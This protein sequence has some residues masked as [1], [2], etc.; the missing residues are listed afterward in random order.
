V[1]RF[2]RSAARLVARSPVT[3]RLRRV[4]CALL[5]A[6]PLLVS[7]SAFGAP[8]RPAAEPYLG[9]PPTSDLASASGVE[10]VE[11]F[12]GVGFDNPVFMLAEPA[13]DR[14][15]IAEQAGRLLSFEA[16]ENVSETRLVLD[17][18]DV[19][20]GVGDSGL[21][22]MAFHPRY[23]EAEAVGEGMIFVAYEH[24]ADDTS[25]SFRVSRF[26]VDRTTGVADPESELVLIHQS[27]Q[28]PWHE[29]ASMLF[30]PSDGFLYVTVG[31]EGGNACQ[32]GNCQKI[33][34]DLFSGVLRID[35]D[36][37]GGEKSHAPPRQPLTGT[38]AG[39]F[40]PNDNPFAGVPDALEEFYAIG[41]RSPHRMTLDPLKDRIWIADVGQSAREEIDILAPAA[42][43]QW[44]V[45]EGSIPLTGGPPMPNPVIGTWTPPV[46]DYGRNEG[47]TIIGGYVYRGLAIPA[48]QGRYVYGDFL[49]GRIWALGYVESGHG[50][51]VTENER[52]LSTPY[53]GREQGLTS[54][55]IDA[56]GEIYVLT[57]GEQVRLR[58]LVP[59]SPD[60]GNVPL[61]LSATGLFTDLA[62]LTT[63]DSL[64]PYDVK[65]AL[66][67]DGAAKRRWVSVPTGAFV[68]YSPDRPWTFPAGT[69]FVK[70]FE[71]QLD[72]SG[73]SSLHRLETRVLVVQEDQRIYGV[74]YKWRSDQ[75]D[76]DLLTTAELEELEIIDEK[77][78]TSSQRYLYP[79]PLDCLTCHAER[80]GSVLGLRARQFEGM[81]T[82][83]GAGDALEW[84]AAAGYFDSENLE[85]DSVPAFA[86]LDDE[87][88]PVALRARSYLDVNCSHC[89]GGQD[90]DRA[91][92]DARITV[93][94]NHQ[95]IVMGPLLSGSDSE[96]DRIVVPGDVSHSVMHRRTA[97][98]DVDLRMPPLARSVEDE[99]F[100]DVLED[101]IEGMT[102]TTLPPVVCG[103]SAAPWD[104]VSSAD[105]LAGLRA[106]VAI[107]YCAACLCDVNSDGTI[108]ASDALRVLRYAVGN[109]Q[110][111]I[112]PTC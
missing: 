81:P 29:G 23:A 49:N 91:Q 58:R 111:L 22:S 77:G 76:A 9:M 19:T 86:P 80:A 7:G 110:S 53:Y 47:G 109:P 100:V 63:I 94:L 65:V 46:H 48:L 32:F 99:S 87:L 79:G 13:G 92:W 60:P 70:H 106:A 4:G 41:L 50:I 107:D 68:G 61:T 105:A 84:F 89:H 12:A 75:S 104:S 73:P 27:D 6:A 112:C 43:F 51:T 102:A 33:D 57:L 45:M 66:W 82:P 14:I 74:T 37:I 103:D 71:M 88:A 35:V 93:P 85:R 16:V 28:N 36:K 56:E 64:V 5:F 83:E 8:A 69:V 52:L 39:Y 55:G 18:S 25:L 59:A 10:L 20:Q 24:R 26:H 34:R 95:N 54:F 44:N 31:D 67:S 90:L 38:T 21:L 15:W 108:G 101:W 3:R 78:A 30:R 2:D 17:L 11:A 1:R 72:R 42:N 97:T 40:I 62:T 96:E 98:T